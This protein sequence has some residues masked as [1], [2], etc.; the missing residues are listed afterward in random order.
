[1]NS[2]CEKILM[3]LAEKAVEKGK[4]GNDNLPVIMNYYLPD[5]ENY[6][7]S[8][9][10]SVNNALVELS[11]IGYIISDRL[12]ITLTLRGLE[13]YFVEIKKRKIGF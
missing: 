11:T 2:T 4:E 7:C 10:Q 13:Y 5:I 3:V 6:L 9:K 8:D 12:A 1:M